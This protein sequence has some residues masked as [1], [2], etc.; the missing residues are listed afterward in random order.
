MSW[1]NKIFSSFLCSLA[2]LISHLPDS[3]LY[4]LSDF[5]AFFLRQIISYRKAVIIQNLSRAFPDLNYKEID[6]LRIDFYKNF[7]D[8]FIETIMSNSM[9]KNQARERYKIK[10][11]HLI[12]ELINQGKNVIALGGHIANW[13]WVSFISS[14]YSFNCYTLYKPL[15]SKIS[16]N[17]ITRFR[18]RFGM[19]LLPMNIAAKFILNNKNE[20]SLYIF[21][22]DQS[23]IKNNKDHKV[24]FLNQSTTFFNGGARIAQ[25]INAVVIYLSLSRVKRGYY[26]LELIHIPYDEHNNCELEIISKYS[27]LLED[28]IRKQPANWLWSHKRWKHNFKD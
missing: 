23:P 16:E 21:V 19:N 5:I 3:I 8:V 24:W 10:N 26:E 1:H 6:Q 15:S 17:I 27:S 20:K 13:E 2:K 14:S 7:S 9:N 28:N 11:P 25:S 18:K 22:G 4:S 12:Q